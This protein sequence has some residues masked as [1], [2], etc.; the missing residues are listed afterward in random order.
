VYVAYAARP[1]PPPTPECIVDAPCSAEQENMTYSPCRPCPWR[2]TGEMQ[3]LLSKEV[4]SAG[5]VCMVRDEYAAGDPVVDLSAAAEGMAHGVVGTADADVLAAEAA[6]G[7]AAY[8]AL[9]PGLDPIA[10]A[11]AEAAAA[12][13]EAAA[14]A[15]ANRTT[16]LSVL[17]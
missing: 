14:A 9:R 17:D 15:A 3:A 10:A 2:G 5:T 1:A 16:S 7:R 4:S 8:L 6:K 13:E 12:E 11:A